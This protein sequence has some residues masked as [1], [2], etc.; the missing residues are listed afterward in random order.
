MK[1]KIQSINFFPQYF[2]TLNHCNTLECF[3]FYIFLFF[4]KTLHGFCNGMVIVH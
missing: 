3:Y 2:L 1:N 4:L